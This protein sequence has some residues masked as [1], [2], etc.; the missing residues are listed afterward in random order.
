MTEAREKDRDEIASQLEALKASLGKELTDVQGALAAA[1]IQAD[2]SR[3]KDH[4]DVKGLMTT[5]A[6]QVN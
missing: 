5:L 1:S 3:T 4:E 2:K 6:E